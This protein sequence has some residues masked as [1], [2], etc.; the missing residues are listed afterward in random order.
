M[1]IKDQA[2]GIGEPLRLRDR[3]CA[4]F[5]GEGD[6]LRARSGGDV[7]DDRSLSVEQADAQQAGEDH[8]AREKSWGACHR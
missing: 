7:A 2:I 6:A 5:D 4:E 3:G 8:Q 1:K